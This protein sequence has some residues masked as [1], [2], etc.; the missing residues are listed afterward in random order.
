MR[1]PMRKMRGIGPDTAAEWLSFDPV[2]CVGGSWVAP[3]GPFDREIV[4]ALA[5]KAAALR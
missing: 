5:S 2:L 1:S 3:R 4:E